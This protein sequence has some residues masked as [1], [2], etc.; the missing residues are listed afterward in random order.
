MREKIIAII[1]F[2]SLILITPVTAT[3]EI[4]FD[5]KTKLHEKRQLHLI[6]LAVVQLINESNWAKV[7]DLGEDYSLWL[8]NIKRGLNGELIIVELDVEIHG[9]AIISEGVFIAGRHL[10]IPY[11]PSGAEKVNP[12]KA[13]TLNA[14]VHEQLN[15]ADLLSALVPF[16]CLSQVP[17]LGYQVPMLEQQLM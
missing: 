17:L 12:D 3:A 11:D 13:D 16:F 10:S 4:K 9:P 15:S 5:V 2:L 14:M 7:K 6:K 8:K 1:V